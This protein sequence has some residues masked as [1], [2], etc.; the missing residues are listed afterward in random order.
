MKFSV[1]FNVSADSYVCFKVKPIFTS[2]CTNTLKAII[3]LCSL[4]FAIT[5]FVATPLSEKEFHRVRPYPG[6]RV[7]GSHWVYGQPGYTWYIIA[8]FAE[9]CCGLSFVVFFATMIPEFSHFN[10]ELVL[11]FQSNDAKYD[12]DSA[13]S[14]DERRK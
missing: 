12:A 13:H 14:D 10:A 6:E 2:T 9:W 7:P 3:G 8:A 5:N 11:E 1:H 4:L